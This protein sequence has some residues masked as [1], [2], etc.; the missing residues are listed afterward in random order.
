MKTPLTQM[1]TGFY[2]LPAH[3]RS[4]EKNLGYFKGSQEWKSF[5]DTLQL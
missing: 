2:L 5:R 1:P 3:K 4:D